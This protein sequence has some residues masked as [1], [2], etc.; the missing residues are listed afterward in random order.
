MVELEVALPAAPL[1]EAAGVA[2]VL[3][4]PVEL[5]PGTMGVTR[6][7]TGATGVAVA[8]GAEASWRVSVCY[9]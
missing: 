5:T 1:V 2:P 8:T 3:R 4:A 9:M 7:G 6:V